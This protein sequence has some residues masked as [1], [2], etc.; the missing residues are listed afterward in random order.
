MKD[1]RDYRVEFIR[2]VACIMVIFLHTYKG[3]GLDKCSEI[4]RGGIHSFLMNGVPLFLMIIGFCGINGKRNYWSKLYNTCL[5]LV[6]PSIIIIIVTVSIK[7]W[8]YCN[9]LIGG[10]VELRSSELKKIFICMMRGDTQELWGHLWYVYAYLSIIVTL[11]II[12]YMCKET[13][14]I[15]E[16]S[17][18][19][20]MNAFAIRKFIYIY[21]GLF[22]LVKDALYL[23]SGKFSICNSITLFQPFLPEIVYV[24]IGYDIRIMLE[25]IK[26]IEHIKL[27]LFAGWCISNVSICFLIFISNK[28]GV[29]YLYFQDSYRPIYFISSICLFV[30][31]YLLADSYCN[32]YE[33]TIYFFGDKTLYI[34]LVH[35]IWIVKLSNM[36][37]LNNIKYLPNLIKWIFVSIITVIISFITGY[38]FKFIYEKLLKMINYER[39]M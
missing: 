35:Y 15:E 33:R 4:I 24:L 19:K 27:N 11:P 38:I 17:E 20:V 23:M 31:C 26:E 18:I 39:S 12:K 3:S 37:L 16:N 14:D 2:I 1:K 28:L 21:F 32:R 22:E 10:S 9:N 8:I 34:Y 29:S 25:K 13:K 36:L 30:L 5:R 6:L 7:N